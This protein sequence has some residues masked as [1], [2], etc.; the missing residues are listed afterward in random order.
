MTEDD[1]LRILRASDSLLTSGHYVYTG[2]EHSEVYL[3]KNGLF[4]HT[5]DT[6][7]VCREIASRFLHDCVQVVV[8]PALGGIVLAQWTA[9]HLSELSG[10]EVLAAYAEKIHGVMKLRRGH[11]KVV[12]HKRTLVV[13]DTLSTGGSAL[14]V[15]SA[16]RKCSGEVVG[17]GAINNG[18]GVA[19]EEIGVAKLVSLVSVR[20]HRYKV[21]SCPMCD[22]NIPIVRTP[23]HGADFEKDHPDYP[24]GYV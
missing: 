6:S 15:V 2:G 11:D 3:D 1:V 12:A 14:E 9:H 23:G 4:M 18:G 16:V 17:L 13:E 5:R 21:G 7:A 8:G 10:C 20:A 22:N 24:G 19:A